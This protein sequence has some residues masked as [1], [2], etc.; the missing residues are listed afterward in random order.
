MS[1]CP[2]GNYQ[3]RICAL[4][5][6]WKQVSESLG[7]P[8]LTA[9]EGALFSFDPITQTLVVKKHEDIISIDTVLVADQAARNG[10]T[11]AHNHQILIQHADPLNGDWSL[12]VATDLTPGAWVLKT[13]TMAKQNSNAVNIQGGS[14]SGIS[15]PIDIFSGGTGAAN[16]PQA[17]TNLTLPTLTP[18]GIGS[19]TYGID[20]SLSD[21]WAHA[22]AGAPAYQFSNIIP[23]K[24][25][26]FAYTHGDA[27]PPSFPAFVLWPGNVPPPTTT[28]IGNTDLYIFR[29]VG[30]GIYGEMIPD[31]IP[32]A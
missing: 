20:W 14:I 7:H 26:Y 30:G 17:R 10:T 5:E 2:P 12:W 18:A 11:P 6:A 24:V 19:A 8:P 3:A 4:E 27:G 29:A 9:S 13:G 31:F 28:P 16:V 22:P 32:P 21:N 23:G 25:L 15:P 1:D